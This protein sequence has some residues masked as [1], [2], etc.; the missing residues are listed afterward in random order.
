[1][2]S[3]NNTHARARR[4]PA[5][6]AGQERRSDVF[7]RGRDYE[8]LWLQR[9]PTILFCR[10]FQSDRR[11]CAPIPTSPPSQIIGR[12]RNLYAGYRLPWKMIALDLF[13]SFF[14]VSSH[15]LCSPFC[16]LSLLVVTQIRGNIAGSSPPLPTKVRALHFYREHTSALPSLVDLRRIV[17]THARR[18]RS[19]VTSPIR[20]WFP[21]A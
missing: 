11:A 10:G 1:M 12:W 7:L 9:L 19:R 5:P 3:R 15:L 16:S 18:S 6:V 2:A 14:F 17:P 20:R 8:F 4:Q 21:Y 13:F